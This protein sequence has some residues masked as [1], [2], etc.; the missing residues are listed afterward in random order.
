MP[1]H[2]IPEPIDSST[3]VLEGVRCDGPDANVRDN[4]DGGQR[5]GDQYLTAES[6]ASADGP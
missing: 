2:E 1:P 6:L 5:L 3:V 4:E